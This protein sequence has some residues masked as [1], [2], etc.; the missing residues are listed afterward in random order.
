MATASELKVRIS[1]DTS[2]VKKG[3]AETKRQVKDLSKEV[4]ETTKQTK[5][6]V[7]GLGKT[8]LRLAAVTHAFRKLTKATK[9]GIDNIYEYGKAFNT[10][11]AKNMD[12]LSSAGLYFKNSLGALVAPIINV[13]TPAVEYIV[14]KIVKAMN[15]IS[16]TIA[17]LT[18]QKTW[19]R[20]VYY[21]TEYK[22]S[23]DQTTKSANK[24]KAS[25]LGIDE[26]NILSKDSGNGGVAQSGKDYKKMFEEV[27]VE[28]K[29]TFEDVWE[30]FIER[31]NS[32][33]SLFAGSAA[34]LFALKLGGAFDGLFATSAATGLLGKFTAV[35][36]AAFG[37]FRLGNW[38]Y[39]NVPGIRHWA[40]D[41]MDAGLGEFIDSVKDG[42]KI[43]WDDYEE[44]GIEWGDKIWKTGKD[45]WNKFLDFVGQNNE[46]D[47]TVK[48]VYWSSTAKTALKAA[49]E[50]LGVDSSFVDGLPG[51]KTTTYPT[52]A[53]E[54]WKNPKPT[55]PTPKPTPTPTP[56]PTTPTPTKNQ[57][58]IP[59]YI[60]KRAEGGFVDSGQLF[61]ARENGQNELVGHIGNKTAVANNDQIIESI[62]IATAQGNAEGNMLLRQMVVALNGLL[63]K[64]T[65]VEAVV[66]ADSIT[67]G[68][69][70][71]NLRNGRTTV[72]VG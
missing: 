52:H 29:K 68:L 11:M 27:E 59:A 5:T 60:T 65:T 2:G 3:I 66:T 20:A 1:A 13:I 43:M 50:I 55:T 36:L 7:S 28:G 23:I 47:V 21:Q 51:E 69:A 67:N 72:A 38:L 56:T 44:W 63:A 22:D 19:T 61:M 48:N 41:L 8:L 53:D 64:D 39:Y 4:K 30:D 15:Y 10:A 58:Y 71:Q 62:R 33:W 16:K 12:K 25:L 49:L 31:G 70:R 24:L 42:W 14:D 34:T 9:E 37:G 32:K 45:A 40:D 17:E 54:P 26:L 35:L 18:G 6:Q 57:S 46:I